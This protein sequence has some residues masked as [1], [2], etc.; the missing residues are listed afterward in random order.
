MEFTTLNYLN[1]AIICLNR[2]PTGF[3]KEMVGNQDVSAS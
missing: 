3:S 2:E 1:F